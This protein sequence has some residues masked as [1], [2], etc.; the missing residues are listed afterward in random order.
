MSAAVFADTK[1][2]A[3]E[4]EAYQ[5]GVSHV[6]TQTGPRPHPDHIAGTSVRC[7]ARAP[8]HARAHPRFRLD[9]VGHHPVTP[10]RPERL[11]DRR[12]PARFLVHS[13]PLAGQQRVT[14]AIPACCSAAIVSLNRAVIFLREQYAGIEGVNP[15]K[16]PGGCAPPAPSGCPPICSNISS[17]PRPPH[18]RTAAQ[19]RPD[20]S[21]L[22][23]RGPPECRSAEG[24]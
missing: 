10:G 6:L 3:W 21:P 20:P 9:L 16:K 18:R 2:P 4:E 11:P 8:G 7:A 24:I 5:Q 19:T 15:S 1:E 17:F 23:R 22:W 13:H 12:R 14:E